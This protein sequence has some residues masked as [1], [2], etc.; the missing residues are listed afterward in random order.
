MIKTLELLHDSH[1]ANVTIL[2]FESMVLQL[3]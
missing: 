1:Q 2:A 3:S